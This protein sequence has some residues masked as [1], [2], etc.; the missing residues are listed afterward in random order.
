MKHNPVIVIALAMLLLLVLSIFLITM[1]RNNIDYYIKVNDCQIAKTSCK[2]VLDDENA[3]EINILPRGIPS[4]EKLTISVHA[5]GKNGQIQSANI[6]FEA[7][8]IDTTTPQYR[9]YK[10]TASSFYGSG[11]LALCSLSKQNWLAHLVVKKAG[12]VW[13]VELPFK[14]RLE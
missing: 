11:F 10:K 14:K 1:D 2:V 4:T 3:I 6:A 13:A 7:L 9:L 5:I 12:K 8:E